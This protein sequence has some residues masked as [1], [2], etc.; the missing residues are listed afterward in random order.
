MSQTKREISLYGKS[1]PDP[2]RRYGLASR[3]QS[4]HTIRQKLSDAELG[5][6]TGTLDD[7]GISR[8]NGTIL[9]SP[10]GAEAHE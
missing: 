6:L 1:L 8:P 3:L 10:T 9:L 7:L 5:F 4:G 2:A